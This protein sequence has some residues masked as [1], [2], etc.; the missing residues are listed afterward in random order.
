MQGWWVYML[1]CADD[2]LYTGISTAPARRLREHNES[3]K[4]A[5]YTRARRPVVPVML[6]PAGDRATAS[7]LEARIKRLSRGQKQQLL[8]S[9]KADAQSGLLP[10]WIQGDHEHDP[11]A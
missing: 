10:L 6:V 11:L 9:L 1:R 8:A 5:R 3:P 4:G 7:R 2:S